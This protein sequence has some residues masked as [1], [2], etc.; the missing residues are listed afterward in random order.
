[1]AEGED[2]RRRGLATDMGRPPKEN[3]EGASNHCVSWKLAPV[4]MA[5][6]AKLGGCQGV[7]ILHEAVRRPGP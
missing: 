3:E 6:N 4:I 7:L 2:P 5:H 1:M